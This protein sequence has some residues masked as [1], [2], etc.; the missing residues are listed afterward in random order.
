LQ[1]PAACAVNFIND[2]VGGDQ[3]QGEEMPLRRSHH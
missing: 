2:L 1:Q 3:A